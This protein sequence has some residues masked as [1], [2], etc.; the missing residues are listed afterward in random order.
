MSRSFVSALKKNLGRQ[1]RDFHID[2]LHVYDTI[3]DRI[4]NPCKMK[5]L[6]FRDFADSCVCDLCGYKEIL[7]GV[8]ENP[9]DL[10]AKE[11]SC[12]ACRKDL[13]ITECKCEGGRYH[14]GTSEKPEKKE[15][16]FI[17]SGEC[18]NCKTELTRMFGSKKDR[19]RVGWHGQC[20][21]CSAILFLQ[22]PVRSTDTFEKIQYSVMRTAETKKREYENTYTRPAMSQ[23]KCPECGTMV[24]VSLRQ[25]DII[26]GFATICSGCNS[27]LMVDKYVGNDVS[28]R[29]IGKLEHEPMTGSDLGVPRHRR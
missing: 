13:M 15:G 24:S 14:L 19:N 2:E 20:D 6:R 27:Y 22:A 21:Y 10:L 16:F 18:P 23:G 8:P 29:M 5:P 4:R 7:V 11:I 1:M 25:D 9:S 3:G 12:P 28:F 26:T 17:Q